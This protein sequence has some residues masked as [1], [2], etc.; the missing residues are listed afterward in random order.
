MIQMYF[1]GDEKKDE[2]ILNRMKQNLNIL[3]SN[4]KWVK[5]KNKVF[6]KKD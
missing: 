5:N 6:Y 1:N 4:M 2:I 3:D